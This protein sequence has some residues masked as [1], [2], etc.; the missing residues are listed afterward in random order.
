M[1]Y[2]NFSHSFKVI[3]LDH[4]AGEKADSLLN[5]VET[6]IV[7]KIEKPVYNNKMDIR[8]FFQKPV[9]FWHQLSS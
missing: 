5:S 3:D 4:S 1:V 8:P 9:F 7:Q 2:Y 6:E